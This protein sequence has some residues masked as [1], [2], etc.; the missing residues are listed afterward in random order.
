M[1]HSATVRAVEGGGPVF[2]ASRNGLPLASVLFILILILPLPPLPS[3]PARP[4]ADYRIGFA[5]MLVIE[6]V[7]DKP[8]F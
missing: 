6:M 4:V 1:T 3:P 5:A 8:L 2:L 7:K